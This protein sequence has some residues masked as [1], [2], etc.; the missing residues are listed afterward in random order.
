MPATYLDLIRDNPDRASG[1]CHVLAYFVGMFSV[2]IAE[3]NGRYQIRPS[4]CQFHEVLDCFKVPFI[5]VLW[6][7]VCQLVHAYI[8]PV[9]LSSACCGHGADIPGEAPH[10]LRPVVIV[11]PLPAEPTRELAPFLAN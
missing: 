5:G 6:S 9:E 1:P 8:L 10:D 4:L 3:A 2:E 11:P 7:E